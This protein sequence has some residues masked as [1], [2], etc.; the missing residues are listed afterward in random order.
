MKTIRVNEEAH[1]TFKLLAAM[2]PGRTLQDFMAQVAAR[3]QAR[4]DKRKK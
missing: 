1:H 2:K 4:V 3:E